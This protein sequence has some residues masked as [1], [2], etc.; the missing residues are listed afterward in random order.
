MQDVSSVTTVVS[1]YCSTHICTLSDLLLMGTL[2]FWSDDNI[3]WDQ[4]SNIS[5]ALHL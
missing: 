1:L 2:P 3:V 4:T 5:I